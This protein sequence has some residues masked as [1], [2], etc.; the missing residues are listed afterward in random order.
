MKIKKILAAVAATAVAL[1]TMAVSAF[2]ADIW[3]GSNDLGT[4]WDGA[5]AL[6]IDAALFADV[7]DGS[8]IE[9]GYT[10][11]E[12]DYYNLKIVE[13]TDG[14]PGLSS[15]TVDPQWGTIGVDA[16]STSYSFTI[17]AD[18]VARIQ[19]NGMVIQG[20]G[21]TI[22]KVAVNGAASA[23]AASETADAPVASETADAPA[24]DTAPT[25]AA[26]TGNAPAAAMVSV[27]A[28]AGVAAIA[29]KK[30]K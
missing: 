23:P 18:D 19:A 14:W 25:T 12:A 2:A 9:I 11:G 26:A 5:K 4:D 30:R 21:V 6:K 29:S 16:G 13:N 8:T 7:A 10:T 22:T 27:M 20:Y 24:A 28:V 3:T 17:N 15:P 1:S